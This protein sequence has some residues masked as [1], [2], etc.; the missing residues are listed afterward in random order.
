[1]PNL[2]TLRNVTLNKV[3]LII[4]ST[5]TRKWK[6]NILI[7]VLS[8]VKIVNG[9]GYYVNCLFFSSSEIAF[10]SGRR[11]S[12]GTQNGETWNCSDVG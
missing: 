4:F 6:S 5:F 2:K 10:E 11:C 1:M 9:I 3:Q 8:R 12:R 7:L